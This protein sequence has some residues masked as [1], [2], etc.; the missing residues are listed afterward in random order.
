[1]KNKFFVILGKQSR[2][3]AEPAEWASLRVTQK[4]HFETER[5]DQSPCLSC[6]LF[7]EGTMCPH[8]DDCSR[9]DAFQRIAAAS[10]SLSKYKDVRSMF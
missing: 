8:V 5:L 6:H 10:R 1:V 9:I 2:K 4:G 3:N 7:H